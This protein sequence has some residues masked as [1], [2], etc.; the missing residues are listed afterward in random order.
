MSEGC[1]GWAGAGFP[2]RGRA[3]QQKSTVFVGLETSMLKISVAVANDD[4]QGEVRCLGK[5][6]NTW[7]PC[8]A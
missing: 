7:R 5:I 3:I 6:D 8:G 2:H 1:A 4:R